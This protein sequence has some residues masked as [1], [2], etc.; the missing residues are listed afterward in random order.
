[1]FRLAYCACPMAT[2]SFPL[3]AADD[4]LHGAQEGRFFHGYD[5]SYCYLPLYI[6]SGEHLLCAR[7]RPSNIDAAAGSIGEL[8]RQDASNNDLPPE[9]V[10][11]RPTKGNDR[12]KTAPPQFGEIS[13]LG[14]GDSPG[15][16]NGKLPSPLRAGMAELVDA[17]DSKSGSGNR[18]RVQVSLPAPYP[19]VSQH[20]SAATDRLKY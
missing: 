5:K 8:K 7:R 13:G 10:H 2:E 12:D 19:H 14:L 16:G 11:N 17:P 1:M 6:F 18:V 15:S 20:A 9:T 4:P 3:D